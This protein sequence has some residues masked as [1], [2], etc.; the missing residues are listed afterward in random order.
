VTET[1]AS[2]GEGA[3]PI[4]PQ[5]RLATG[6]EEDARALSA[7]SRE[8]AAF[9]R[10]CDRLLVGAG[11]ALAL[12]ALLQLLQYKYGRDQGIYAVVADSVVHGGLPYRDSWDFKPPGIFYVYALAR[13]LFGSGQIGIRLLEALGFAAL[14][15]VFMTLSKR[16][17]GTRLAGFIGAVVAILVNVQLE[18]WH[19]S[20]PESFGGILTMVGLLLVTDPAAVKSDGSVARRGWVSWIAAGALFGTAGLMKPQLAGASGV[21]A[22]Y[23]AWQMHRAGHGWK[24]WWPP[25]VSLAG[26]SLLPIL[27]IIGWFKARGAWGEL[28]HTLFVFAPGYGATT[29]YP[30]WWANYLFYAFELATVSASGIVF[31]GLM[32]ALALGKRTPEL[33]GLLLVFGIAAL[34]LLG[35]AVQSKFFP[36]HFA[37]TFPLFAFVAG[38][39]WWKLWQA[40]KSK[41]A[42]AVVAF[43]ALVVFL[44]RARTAT[45]DLGETFWDRSMQ[46]TTALLSGDPAQREA[47]DARL[48]SVAD[49]SYGQNMKVVR[50]LTANTSP[51]DSVYIW[52]FE[53]FIYDAAKRRPATR[54]IYNVAQRVS[55][56]REE[57]RAKLMEDLTRELPKAI[58]VEHRDVFPVV[59][60][61]SLDS[62]ASLQGF[63]ALKNL[64][65]TR[66][67]FVSTID[68]FDIYRLR[69][70]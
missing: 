49:V 64:I 47:V 26:G 32:L 38:L 63:W 9:E 25:F 14:V 7:S 46:R 3:E 33:P 1:N 70:E 18:F 11:A 10:W 20:Q 40:S 65:D 66:Y 6:R 68:D 57:A 8:Q 44:A 30:E 50:W 19:T 48:Y 2:T 31:V 43:L 60:G 37:G 22:V 15:P 4:A 54:F 45:R 23:L 36:Y 39:G 62:E 29:W 51:N 21:A 55:W 27:L 17:F 67:L 58:V 12:F 35:I 28:H 53:P 34:H 24:R 41:G 13:A 59:T 52:G 61:D 56:Y 42:I 69:P 16:L 5:A